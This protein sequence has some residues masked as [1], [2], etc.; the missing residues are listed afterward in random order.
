MDYSRLPESARRNV[1]ELAAEPPLET[2]RLFLG[3]QFGDSESFDEV[4]SRLTVLAGT[5][6]RFHQRELHALE[7]VIADP[8]TEPGALARLVAWDAN[9]VLDDE[10]DPAALAFL[11]EVAQMLREVIEAAPASAERW[12]EWPPSGL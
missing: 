9:W 12:R 5:N 4:R 3:V 10:S 8:P 6:I 7:A 2:V 1:E 11:R